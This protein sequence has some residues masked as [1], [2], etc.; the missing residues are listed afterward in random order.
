MVGVAV[1]FASCVVLL[2]ATNETVDRYIYPTYT[3]ALM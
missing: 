1:F 2:F 3:H